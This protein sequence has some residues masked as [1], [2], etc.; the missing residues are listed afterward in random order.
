MW[1][2]K[3]E[4]ADVDVVLPPPV[5]KQVWDGEKFVPMTLYKNKGWPGI[6]ETEWLCNTYG[7]AGTYKNGQYWE[8]SQAGN[9]TVMDEKVY[10]WYQMKWG[11]K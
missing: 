9:F 7:P 6:T 8:Y 3:I 5:R 10:T 2:Q 1:T 11:N 4:Y